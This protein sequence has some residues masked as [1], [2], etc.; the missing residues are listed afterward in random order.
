MNKKYLS[1]SGIKGQKWGIRRYQ[2]EDGSLTAA[3]KARYGPGG[4]NPGELEKDYNTAN[5][6]GKKTVLEGT[7]KTINDASKIVAE[8]GRNKS[9]VINDKNYAN[10]KDEELRSK[11]NRLTMERTYGELT[12]DTK[13]VR[14]G[15]DWT[16]E[17]LQTT[18]AV[19]GIGATIVGTIVAIQQIKMGGQPKKGGS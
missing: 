14:S 10:M 9:K 8:V 16:R 6:K 7:S 18:G 19:V 15:S 3:G 17:L 11:I 2:N 4:T 5:L 13:R 1:H 12:G